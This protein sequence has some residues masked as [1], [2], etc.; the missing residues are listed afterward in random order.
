MIDNNRPRNISSNKYFHYNAYQNTW[1]RILAFPM[2]DGK[3]YEYIELALTPVIG[4]PFSSWE[5]DVA[6]GI[7]RCVTNTPDSD[8]LYTRELHPAVF[9][10]MID[11]VGLTIA[12]RLIDLDFMSRINLIKLREMKVAKLAQ[13]TIPQLVSNAKNMV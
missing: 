4:D 1:S 13:I 12:D 7:V 9:G 6:P 11:H 10:T 5:S 8:D 3:T 2:H